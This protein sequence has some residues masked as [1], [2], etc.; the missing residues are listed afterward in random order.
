MFLHTS[1]RRSL[2]SISPTTYLSISVLEALCTELCS[3]RSNVQSILQ[4]CAFFLLYL[5]PW[6]SLDVR[7]PKLLAM[8]LNSTEVGKKKVSSLF[9]ESLSK[10]IFS[11]LFDDTV[12]TAV[13]IVW[14]KKADVARLEGKSVRR[15]TP[16]WQ[17]FSQL[18]LDPH[19]HLLLQIIFHTEQTFKLQTKTGFRQIPNGMI[20]KR[21]M[22]F[23]FEKLTAEMKMS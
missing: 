6:T 9:P 19:K 18:V 23:C 4:W 10:H 7:Q 14:A 2:L 17:K 5:C 22:L 12:G 16:R 11:T 15:Q 21:K 3:K 1:L 13:E 8:V 20:G